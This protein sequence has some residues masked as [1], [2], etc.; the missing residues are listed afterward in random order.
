MSRVPAPIRRLLKPVV[1]PFR[2]WNAISRGYA[3]DFTPTAREGA[4]APARDP[5]N[6]LR[7]YCKNHKEGPGIYKWDHYFEIYDRHFSRF[8]GQDVHILEIGV[9]GGGS[10]GMWKNY[11]GPKASIY[12][13]DIQPECRAYERDGI[14]IFIGDQADRNFW[15]ATLKEIPALDVVI[16]DGGHL[17]EQQIVTCEELLPF[18]RRGG[19]YLCEDI[20]GEFNR[21]TSYVQGLEYKLNYCAFEKEK[22]KCTPVQSLIDSIHLYPYVSVIEKNKTNVPE[23]MTVRYGNQWPRYAS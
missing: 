12:G 13:V 19:V 3:H 11:F 8:R 4:E 2:Q 17:P 21:F 15:R 5:K 1:Q 14:K 6:P 18:V 23:L 7:D 22:S 9:F 16:D 10:L 20:I